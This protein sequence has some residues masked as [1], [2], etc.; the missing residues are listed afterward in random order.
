M[1]PTSDPNVIASTTS[2]TAEATPNPEYGAS[3]EE[4]LLGFDDHGPSPAEAVPPPAEKQSE[5][6]GETTASEAPKPAEAAQKQVEGE[7]TAEAQAIEAGKLD[8]R[9]VPDNL[10]E[11]VKNSPELSA[12]YLDHLTLKDNGLTVPDV[13]AIKAE[14]PQGLE[15]LKAE[16]AE[17]GQYKATDEALIAGNWNQKMEA[18]HKIFDSIPEA[19][20]E[21][22]KA[23]GNTLA[24]K[25]PQ[26]YQEYA[27]EIL[28]E[29]LK[30][31][32]FEPFMA[33]V[34]K[35]IE[36]NAGNPE[37]I[38][39]LK[40]LQTWVQGEFNIGLPREK[41]LDLREANLKAQE[42]ANAT[43]G[44]EKETRE[45]NEFFSS[46]DSAATAKMGEKVDAELSKIFPKEF[47]EPLRAMARRQIVSEIADMVATEK[48]YGER[49]LSKTGEL[50]FPAGYN[51]ETHKG[52]IGL[53]LGNEV[54]DQLVSFIATDRQPLIEKAVREV[55][56]LFVAN[57]IAKQAE[58]TDK[59][60]QQ[61][62]RADITSSSNVPT[63]PGR[64]LKPKDI[65]Y[66]KTSDEDILDS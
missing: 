45:A 62:S 24:A 54:R 18:A 16:R 44:V 46:I 59:Q 11:T 4:Q 9:R 32:N 5:T 29:T 30:A 53:R 22:V 21:I 51:K 10:R 6:T 25:N 55:G 63:R 64:T 38:A 58:R 36:A 3:F 34:D 57:F 40:D 8:F 23:F 12:A 39:A 42:Q 48:Q 61:E 65:D 43:Q 31:N 47:P 2:T 41:Q 26:A 1:A 52:V 33:G 17:V 13:L 20:P 49:A 37:A 66:A 7:K 35:I 28:T 15:G 27:K 14:L 60:K 56:G 50:I 19:A